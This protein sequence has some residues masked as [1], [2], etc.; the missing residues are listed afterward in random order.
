MNK[1]QLLNLIEVKLRLVAFIYS[2]NSTALAREHAILNSLT[3]IKEA[4]TNLEEKKDAPEELPKQTKPR[5]T[6]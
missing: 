2:Q 4:I 3:E 5:K 1:E 6:A